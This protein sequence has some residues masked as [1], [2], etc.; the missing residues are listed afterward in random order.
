MAAARHRRAPPCRT[1]RARRA[2][3]RDRQSRRAARA[4]SRPGD[5][6]A[7]AASYRPTS[8]LPS[9]SA[10]AASCWRSVSIPVPPADLS[11]CRD[12]LSAARCTR[13]REHVELHDARRDAS[14]RSDDEDVARIELR[15]RPS[16]TAWRPSGPGR[17]RTDS[18][19]PTRAP[20]WPERGV[21]VDADADH[22]DLLS[23]VEE[24]GVL[25]TVRLHLDRSALG[26]RLGEEG[27]D[28]RLAAEVAEA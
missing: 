9:S 2:V 11:V 15:C 27:E 21:G 3:A 26:P 23:V 14:V 7:T 16:R 17:W 1:R 19:S 12:R 13:R 25:I 6:A 24:R 4:V 8:S 28:D 20:S 5:A 10:S 22:D 18:E